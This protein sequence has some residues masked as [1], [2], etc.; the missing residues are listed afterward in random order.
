MAGL[1]DP[2]RHPFLEQYT[3][4]DAH[5]QLA[6]DKLAR[7]AG[8]FIDYR[9]L[10]ERHLGTIYEGLLEHHLQPI[11]RDAMGFSVDLFNDKGERHRTGSYYTPDFVVQYIV[12]R[13][14]S[15]CWMPPW[16]G[17][18]M[19]RRRSRRYLQ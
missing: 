19:R 13:R 1:F 17:L 6:L 3:V 9:D 5:L 7:V 15:R 10:A 4:G 11:E 18:P 12:G 2:N 8:E 14:S 16:P